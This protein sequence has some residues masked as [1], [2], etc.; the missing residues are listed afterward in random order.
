[1]ILWFSDR[2]LAE[3]NGAL[4]ENFHAWKFCVPAE[5]A[6]LRR[7]NRYTL[8]PLRYDRTKLRATGIVAKLRILFYGRVTMAS[9]S[10][11]GVALTVSVAPDET[12]DPTTM[13]GILQSE[14]T[15]CPRG[16]RYTPSR[17]GVRKG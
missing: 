15:T 10:R 16:G 17:D 6:Y 9:R 11:S 13:R 7:A 3:D 8:V 14:P 2:R 12:G 5:S 4:L 1:M